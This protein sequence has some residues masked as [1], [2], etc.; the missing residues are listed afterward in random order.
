MRESLKTTMHRWCPEK[1]VFTILVNKRA[2]H[3]ISTPCVLHWH[4][5]ASQTLPEYLKIVL[6][7]VT[8]RVNF[9][10]GMGSS[11]QSAL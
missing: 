8:K 7:H 11:F 10:Q 3:V 6:K 5:L 9:Y 1:S 2:P 4:A